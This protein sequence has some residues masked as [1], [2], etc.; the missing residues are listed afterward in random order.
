MLS[1]RAPP[2][3]CGAYD[4]RIWK[5]DGNRLVRA[6]GTGPLTEVSRNWLP[7]DASLPSVQAFLERRTVQTEDVTAS[8]VP[9]VVDV[10]RSIGI[11]SVL[12]TPL[13]REGRPIGVL[14]VRRREPGLFSDKHVGLLQTFADQAVIAIAC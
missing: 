5:L 12:A 4:A 10:A 13:M 9:S 1:S 6:S 8:A 7:F 11:R 14:T 3:L 2:D